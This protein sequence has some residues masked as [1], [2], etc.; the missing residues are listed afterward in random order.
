MIFASKDVVTFLES[1]SCSVGRPRENGMVGVS[2]CDDSDAIGWLVD[3]V[4]WL[5]GEGVSWLDAGNSSIEGVASLSGAWEEGK[6][7]TTTDEISEFSPVG[8]FGRVDCLWHP[9][10]ANRQA[11]D[12]SKAVY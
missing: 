10:K 5:E 8:V 7:E 9:T 11:A 3:N 6:E 1:H 2:S 4:A 12:S